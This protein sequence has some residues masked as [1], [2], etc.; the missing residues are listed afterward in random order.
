MIEQKIEKKLK[1]YKYFKY[2]IYILTSIA[3]YTK[4]FGETTNERLFSHT[5]RDYYAY[6]IGMN[7]VKTREGRQLTVDYCKFRIYSE[8]CT[9]VYNQNIAAITRILGCAR[10]NK[11]ICNHYYSVFYVSW[12]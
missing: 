2:N 8:K 12:F 7:I 9:C 3:I 10:G 6:C 1:K 5:I 11:T 4:R